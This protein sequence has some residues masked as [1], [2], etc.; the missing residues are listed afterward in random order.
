MRKSLLAFL[1]VGTAIGTTTTIYSYEHSLNPKYSFKVHRE[2]GYDY[3]FHCGGIEYSYEAP[4][5]LNIDLS[6]ATNFD[7]NSLFFQ[8]QANF[9]F[10]YL[11]NGAHTFYPVLSFT[12]THHRVQHEDHPAHSEWYGANGILVDEEVVEASEDKSLFTRKY[13]S[14]V[15][16]EIYIEKRSIFS[17]IGWDWRVNNLTSVTLEGGVF[18]DMKNS[19]QIQEV[20][21]YWGYIYSNPSGYQGKAGIEFR[22]PNYLSSNIK[23]NFAKTFHHEFWESSLE[24]SFK[25]IF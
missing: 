18:R 20:D 24:A 22:W 6:A 8:E 5:G 13:F 7:K 16:R 10:N 17:G 11:V 15:S 1:T 4:E 3:D 9:S 12:N 14:S 23:Y 19:L 2:K 25:M 21:K